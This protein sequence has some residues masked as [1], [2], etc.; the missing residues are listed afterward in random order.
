MSFLI[1][2]LTYL[3]RM[4]WGQMRWL[5]VTSFPIHLALWF[6]RTTLGSGLENKRAVPETKK[7]RMEPGGSPTG[8]RGRGPGQRWN[9]A[10]ATVSHINVRPRA[11]KYTLM[12][13]F[14]HSVTV[15]IL[16]CKTIGPIQPGF[17]SFSNGV[18]LTCVDQ[19]S[20]PS[21]VVE[22]PKSPFGSNSHIFCST[23]WLW[24]IQ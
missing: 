14:H 13:S 8:C 23:S 15:Q 9:I 11:L 21:F 1:L 22:S 6:A 24:D 19:A 3:K 17:P 2:V 18:F 20:R 12:W 7:A 16:K 10:L 5:S 4:L